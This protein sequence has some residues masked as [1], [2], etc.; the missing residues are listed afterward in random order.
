MFRGGGAEPEN[1]PKASRLRPAGGT[2]RGPVWLKVTGRWAGRCCLLLC[3]TAGTREGEEQSRGVMGAC[4]KG[5][6]AAQ[7][8][9][10]RP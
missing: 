1:T 3:S 5:Q 4:D 9:T 10:T 7:T 8:K 2:G 6:E